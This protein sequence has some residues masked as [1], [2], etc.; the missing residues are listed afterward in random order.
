MATVRLNLTRVGAYI[1]EGA[2]GLQR[3]ALVLVAKN[4]IAGRVNGQRLKERT[5]CVQV[6]VRRSA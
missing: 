3:T 5:R 4:A 2:E 1:W 6:P